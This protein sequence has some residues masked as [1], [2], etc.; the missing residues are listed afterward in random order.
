MNLMTLV[1]F[2]ESGYFLFFY[3]IFGFLLVLGTFMISILRTQKLP[4]AQL[5]LTA[6]FVLLI[7]FKPMWDAFFKVKPESKSGDMTY[8]LFIL[9]IATIVVVADHLVYLLA[10]SGNLS[11]KSLFVLAPDKTGKP[12]F[13]YQDHKGRIAMYRPAFYP[14][15]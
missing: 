13:I 10:T 9:I 11:K 8:D 12:I 2:F 6:L 3:T 4:I 5:C 15:K 1:E 7:F 14:K